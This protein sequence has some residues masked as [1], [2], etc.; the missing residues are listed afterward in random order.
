[1][2]HCIG[3]RSMV[4]LANNQKTGGFRAPEQQDGF[5]NTRQA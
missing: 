3:V 2:L 1:M 5:D 4:M